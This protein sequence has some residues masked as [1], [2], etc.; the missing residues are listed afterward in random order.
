MVHQGNVTTYIHLNPVFIH[1]PKKVLR[2]S[3]PD[4]PSPNQQ[5]LQSLIRNI[6]ET[7]EMIAYMNPSNEVGVPHT[8]RGGGLLMCYQLDGIRYHGGGYILA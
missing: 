5:F 2:G 4:T 7:E 6:L 3:K 1:F 8:A